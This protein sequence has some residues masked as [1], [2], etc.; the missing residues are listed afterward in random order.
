[1]N[2]DDANIAAATQAAVSMTKSIRPTRL[3]GAEL[4]RD[5]DG[6]SGIKPAIP[7]KSASAK[8]GVNGTRCPISLIAN[9]NETSAI[10]AMPATKIV[11]KNTLVRTRK[12]VRSEARLS[13]SLVT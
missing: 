10:P 12:S 5:G 1:M 7:E 13:L 6:W 3:I 4:M 9:T 8:N 2:R 11:S